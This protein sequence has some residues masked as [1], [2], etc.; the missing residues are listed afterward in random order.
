MKC[1]AK[2]EVPCEE[3]KFSNQ[4]VHSK[5]RYG[6]QRSLSEGH[7]CL[8]CVKERVSIGPRSLNL[9]FPLCTLGTLHKTGIISMLSQHLRYITSK[10]HFAEL[11]IRK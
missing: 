9:D 1:I 2:G 3:C 10:L 11:P 4:S 7:R 6:K 8:I 5:T